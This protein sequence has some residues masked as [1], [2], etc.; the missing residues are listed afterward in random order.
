MKAMV[1]EAFGGPE[2]LV[3][4]E[5]PDPPP[6]GHMRV[7]GMQHRA[8]ALIADRP[9]QFAFLPCRLVKHGE[10]L[11][12]MRGDQAGVKT[13]RTTLTIYDVDAAGITPDGCDAARKLN[14]PSKL[15]HQ[16]L[17][18]NAA[19]AGHCPPL[20]AA[21]DLKQPVIGEEPRE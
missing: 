2:V 15:L 17:Y 8:I 6:P 5:L 11:V 13:L 14:G 21:T 4:R 18:V 7:V 1:C 9:Q 3:M 10:G 16:C 19:T 12:G 20:R